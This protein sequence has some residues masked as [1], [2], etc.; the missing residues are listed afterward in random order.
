MTIAEFGI[1]DYINTKALSYQILQASIESIPGLLW[2]QPVFSCQITNPGTPGTRL[3][4]FQLLWIGH[5]S[6]RGLQT[7]ESF[8]LTLG[9]GQN[10]LYTFDNTKPGG[11]YKVAIDRDAIAQI[12]LEDDAGGK[13]GVTTI[14]G[15]YG[16]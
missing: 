9:A 13:S 8:Q 14:S 12:W 3:V 16:Y 1:T 15:P 6:A 2:L 7:I 10:Y 11:Y 5:Y 4:S